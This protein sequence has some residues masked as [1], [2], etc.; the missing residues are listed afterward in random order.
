MSNKIITLESLSVL[1]G[2]KRTQD[3][4]IVQCHGVFDLLHIGH[5]RHFEESK[6]HGD[7]LVV[8]ITADAYV[9]KG[10]GR[11]VFD[12]HIRS[13]AI[14]A[15]SCIDYVV[16]SDQPT[17]VEAILAIRPHYYA[18]GPDYQNPEDDLTDG[19][20]P[21]TNAIHSVGG[22]LIIT[23]DITFSSSNIINTHSSL[24]SDE[25][26]KFLQG[27]RNQNSTAGI[28]NYLQESD[29][30][31][32][33]VIGETII[34]EYIYCEAL[35]KSGKEPI[36]AIR[37][38]DTE[39]FAGGA[40][41]V[42]NHA[43]SLCSQTSLITF[44]GK[45]DSYEDFLRDKLNTT[46]NPIFLTMDGDK[47]TIVKRRFIESY[48]FQKLL[49]LYIMEGDE[50]DPSD[51]RVLREN[52]EALLPEYDLV[53]AIDYGHGMIDNE[54]VDLLCSKSK[55]LAVNTQTNAANQGFNTISKYS[56]ADFICV[57]EREIRLEVRS[58]KR[59]LKSIAIEVSKKLSCN[60]ILITRGQS[61]C[62]CYSATEG[63][64][65]VPAFGSQVI[66]RVGAGDAV[67]ASASICAYQEAPMEVVGFLGNVVGSEAVRIVGNRNSVDKMYLFKFIE[68]LLK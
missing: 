50:S 15:L 23:D 34:D 27:F 45:T 54:T 18:K 13:E 37:Y 57:S 12:Q 46:I 25:T 64:F 68:T 41:A 7:I 5:I 47:P 61:G 14:A 30:I 51:S 39:K 9:N 65:E 40:P 6:R 33:L 3:L 60:R 17:A 66:D 31:K 43:A 19:I 8:S 49:E 58:Q 26:R 21:E 11:P 22:E 42:A 55:F 52:L 20:T 24:L 38:L 44:L 67:L 36:L 35:G 28:I 48:P 56:R 32:I 16:I 59:D 2:S 63:F 1:L 29:K 53:I 4:K 62:L 10:S